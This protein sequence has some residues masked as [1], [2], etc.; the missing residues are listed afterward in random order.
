MRYPDW[1]WQDQCWTLARI[2][3]LVCQPTHVGRPMRQL[4]AARSWLTVYQLP[5]YA[6]EVNPVEAVWSNRRGLIDGF[7]AKTEL[8]LSLP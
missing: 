2:G 5:A 3:A 4:I 7:V 1:G 6:P 8:D